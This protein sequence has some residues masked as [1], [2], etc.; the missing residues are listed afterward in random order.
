MSVGQ[1][2]VGQ[3]SV[4]QMSV[5]QMSVGQISFGQM[6]VGQMS[7]QFAVKLLLKLSTV[8]TMLTSLSLKLH[9]CGPNVIRPNCFLP[10]DLAPKFQRRLN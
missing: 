6:S 1:M 2:S 7:K 9:S 8:I 10:K 3:M 4:G 5:G